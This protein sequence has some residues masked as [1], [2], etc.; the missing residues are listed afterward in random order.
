MGN[1]VES[2]GQ[3]ESVWSGGGSTAAKGLLVVPISKSK[4]V[5]IGPDQKT[6]TRNQLIKAERKKERKSSK[7]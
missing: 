5:S 7:K 1:M 3:Q 4:N 2:V 6:K